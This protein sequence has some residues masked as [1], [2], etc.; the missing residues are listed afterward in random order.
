MRVYCLA[1]KKTRLT[2]QKNKKFVFE[3]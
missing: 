2:N 3:L 1:I